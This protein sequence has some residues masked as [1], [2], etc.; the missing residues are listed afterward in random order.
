MSFSS[1]QPI[2]VRGEKCVSGM[3]CI[4]LGLAVQ[5]FRHAGGVRPEGSGAGKGLSMKLRF[6]SQT[7][8]GII[9]YYC[10]LCGNGDDTHRTSSSIIDALDRLRD[11]A[12]LKD[13]V[14]L[15]VVKIGEF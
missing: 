1:A 15:V 3:I 7:G 9:R 11:G 10:L 13:D 8:T 4:R 14:T 12:A 2:A 6:E 5:W